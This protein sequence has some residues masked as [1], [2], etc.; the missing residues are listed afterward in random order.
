M[1][2][3]LFS[4]TGK[5]TIV[6]GLTLFVTAALPKPPICALKLGDR[7]SDLVFLVDFPRGLGTHVAQHRGAANT[8]WGSNLARA[9]T[10]K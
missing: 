5:K 3:F 1:G 8:F 10:F 6:R 2:V 4:I 9:L 7:T